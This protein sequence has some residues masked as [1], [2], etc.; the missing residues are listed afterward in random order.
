MP[1]IAT[2]LASLIG[3]G[4]EDAGSLT[5]PPDS[6]PADPCDSSALS[7]ALGTGE[8]AFEA[9]DEGDTLEMV[10]GSQGGWHFVTALE[11]YRASDSAT[12]AVTGYDAETGERVCQSGDAPLTGAVQAVDDCRGAIPN[13]YCYLLDDLGQLAHGECDTPPEL[14]PGRSLELVAEV[15]DA[16]GRSAIAELIVIAAPDPDDRTDCHD[17]TESDTGDTGF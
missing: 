10:H 4:V 6:A 17:G 2:L 15:S 3:C 16:T 8:D 12:F 9:M 11:L 5:P 13:I 7:V 1:L 14:L